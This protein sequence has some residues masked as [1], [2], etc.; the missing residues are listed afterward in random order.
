[1][2][3]LDW[4]FL[5]IF[6]SFKAASAYPSI[7]TSIVIAILAASVA[8]QGHSVNRQR[9]GGGGPFARSTKKTI[10]SQEFR[11]PAASSSPSAMASRSRPKPA[12]RTLVAAAAKVTA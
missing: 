9:Y 12:R 7:M 5:P 10:M 6:D 8:R 2:L 1:V 4:R 11:M 3:H